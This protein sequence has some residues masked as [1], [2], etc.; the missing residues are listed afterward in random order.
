MA[1]RALTG[2]NDLQGAIVGALQ[3]WAWQRQ[4]S[5]QLFE[6]Y[7]NQ[8]GDEARRFG[9]DLLAVLGESRVLMLELKVL[10]TTTHTLMSFRPE[11][12]A[13]CLHLE[14]AGLPLAYAFNTVP[15][16]A[17]H[18]RPQPLDFPERTLADV[19]RATPSR[20]TDQHPAPGHPTLL[21]WLQSDAERPADMSP[22]LGWLMGAEAAYPRDLTN[23]ALLLIYSVPHQRLLAMDPAD[24][25]ALRNALTTNA[26]LTDANRRVLNRLLGAQAEAFAMF[27]RPADT[28]TD[29]ADNASPPPR[30]GSRP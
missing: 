12:H 9:A 30:P 15:H 28:A 4:M 26:Y 27:T 19:A 11:Q 3:V 7:A 24:S 5:A 10:N 23:A 18:D 17:Y 13:M 29:E 1:T 22:A 8:Q 14:K 21:K 16:L 2:E 6:P 20:L 25:L